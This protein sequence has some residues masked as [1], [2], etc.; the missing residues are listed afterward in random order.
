[1]GCPPSAHGEAGC[2]V[3]Q[4]GSV[5]TRGGR[6]GGGGHTD[7]KSAERGTCG[8]PTYLLRESGPC[9]HLT[10]LFECR[11]YFGPRSGILAM[12]AQVQDPVNTIVQPMDPIGGCVPSKCREAGSSPSRLWEFE[13]CM[14]WFFLLFF[15]LWR[16]VYPTW[17]WWELRS[18]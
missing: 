14:G 8:I 11:E 6:G 13:A 9:I 2:Q 15:P 12:R 4:S 17:R 7:T 5:P 1:M 3:M 10:Y 18:G 16:H